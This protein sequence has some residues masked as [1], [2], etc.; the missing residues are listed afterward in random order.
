MSYSPAPV[1]ESGKR[2]LVIES[3]LRSKGVVLPT[4]GRKR[5][6]LPPLS[7]QIVSRADR[8]LTRPGGAGVTSLGD[9]AVTRA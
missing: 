9:S 6:V 7:K 2:S 3:S 5:R 8:T 4:Q 1:E